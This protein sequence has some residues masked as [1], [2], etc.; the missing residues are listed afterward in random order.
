MPRFL[1]SFFQLQREIPGHE[2]EQVFYS[3]SDA[4]RTAKSRIAIYNK[5]CWYG[6]NYHR[7]SLSTWDPGQ[8]RWVEIR[9][10]IVEE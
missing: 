10:G 7:W 3:V 6:G 2:Y 1:V 9:H 8:G 5:M 4:A